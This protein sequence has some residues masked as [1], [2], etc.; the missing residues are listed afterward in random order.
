MVFLTYMDTI[1]VLFIFCNCTVIYTKP[2]IIL[3]F[4]RKIMS[5]IYRV[6]V[7]KHNW[8]KWIFLPNNS[9]IMLFSSTLPVETEVNILEILLKP[10]VLYLITNWIIK[11]NL[12]LLITC[13]GWLQKYLDIFASFSFLSNLVS[14]KMHKH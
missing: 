11:G 6:A 12:T 10:S 2:L 7:M 13:W 3:F 4:N 8:L 9:I 1:N 5:T 14:H